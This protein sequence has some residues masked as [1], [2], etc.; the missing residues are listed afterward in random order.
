MSLIASSLTKWPDRETLHM[1]MLLVFR[2][3]FR[4]CA[5]I[6]DCSEVFIERPSDLLGRA[7]VWSN[8]KHHSTVK[9]LIGIRFL[10]YRCPNST[11]E[12]LSA[13]CAYNI[14]MILFSCSC[15]Q[16][17]MCADHKPLIGLALKLE[18][19]LCNLPRML[20]NTYESSCNCNAVVMHL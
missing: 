14:I 1:T 7:P 11:A 20:L 10:F 15:I 3:F 12:E 16:Q 9:F 6:I 19:Y 17:L 18:K 5:V 8:Y 2:K 4:R 13:M